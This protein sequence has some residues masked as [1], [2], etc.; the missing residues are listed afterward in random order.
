M[1][2]RFTPTGPAQAGAALGGAL[3][4]IA[5]TIQARRQQRQQLETQQF[6]QGALS[7]A[8]DPK[9]NEE[10]TREGFVTN[11]MEI[12][13]QAP[14]GVNVAQILAAGNMV[15]QGLP[16][17]AQRTT[18]KT[19]SDKEARLR[20]EFDLAIDTTDK[21]AR[22]NIASKVAF[23]S[24]MSPADRQRARQILNDDIAGLNL[25]D[26]QDETIFKEIPDDEVFRLARSSD[27]KVANA[28]RPVI[29]ERF[30]FDL[31]LVTE[32][33][34]RETIDVTPPGGGSMKLTH[35]QVFGLWKSAKSNVD[36]LILQDWPADSPEMIQA[37]AELKSYQNALGGSGEEQDSSVVAVWKDSLS[38]ADRQTLEE[39]IEKD[40]SITWEALF[41][42]KDKL[43]FSEK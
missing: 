10:G 5:G 3:T 2:N 27:I 29:K 31:P 36:E 14:P 1:A 8:G 16:T 22:I 13:T 11:L 26:L 9:N 39:A 19:G 35:T 6:M 15:S 38:E 28:M 18:A 24:K 41:E 43:G 34:G 25:E 42:G 40:P 21:K 12:L 32:T 4:D 17:S 30:G 23:N 7:F 20:E 33:G 37:R